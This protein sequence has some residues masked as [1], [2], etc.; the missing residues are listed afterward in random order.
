MFVWHM[1]EKNKKRFA[2]ASSVKGLNEP[3]PGHT[4]SLCPAIMNHDSWPL[5]KV[6]NISTSLTREGEEAELAFVEHVIRAGL[7]ASYLAVFVSSVNQFSDVSN[8]S[9][10]SLS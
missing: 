3:R 5:A 8:I 9:H 2:E 6:F 1:N 10:A 4:S 7:W